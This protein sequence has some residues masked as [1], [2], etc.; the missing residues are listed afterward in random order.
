MEFQFIMANSQHQKGISEAIIKFSKSVLRSLLK[1]IGREV[2]N[3][4]ELN[5]LLAKAMTLF[6]D[7]PLGIKP[8]ERVIGSYLLPNSLLLGRSSKKISSTHFQPNGEIVEDPKQFK[9]TFLF[10]QAS[11]NSSGGLG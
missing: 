5:T 9:N 1:S 8:N 6:N 11:S 10:I 3:L 7:R 2:L 4:N